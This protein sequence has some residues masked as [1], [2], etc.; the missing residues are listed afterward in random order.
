M[1]EQLRYVQ[2]FI[3]RPCVADAL[4][5]MQTVRAEMTALGQRLQQAS[6]SNQMATALEFA[7]TKSDPTATLM[8]QLAAAN[9][10]IQALQQQL[11]SQQQ[12]YEQQ[13]WML[14]QRL[15]DAEAIEGVW[16][17]ELHDLVTEAD[18]LVTSPKMATQLRLAA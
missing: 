10:Q 18:V 5:K 6:L 9:Q 4:S 11:V 14:N 3:M 13:I 12:H 15:T 8:R 17:T 1:S 16:T 7:R 2:P